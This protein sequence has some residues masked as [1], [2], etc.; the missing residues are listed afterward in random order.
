MK[1]KLEILSKLI[2]EIDLLPTADKVSTINDI[3]EQ[4]HSISPFA[5]EPVDFVKWVEADIVEANDYNPN[6]VAPP[7][8]ELLRISI[9]SDGYTQ[10]VV[11]NQEDDKLVVVD[12]FHRT[13]V[14]KECD[15]VRIR[16]KG[17]LPVVQIRA[18][19]VDKSDRIASTIRHNRARG[20]HVVESMSDIVVELKN[21]N[22]TNQRICRELGMDEDEVLRLCQITGLVGLF[23]DQE[24][25]KAWDVEGHITEDDFEELTDDAANYSESFFARTV[26]TK[27]PDRVFHTFDKWECHKAGFYSSSPPDGLTKDD[28]K[29]EYRRFLSDIPRFRKGLE[30][31]VSEWPHSCE[32]YLTNASMNRIAWLGQAALCYSAGIS[33]EFRGGFGLLTKDEQQA[34]NELALECLNKWIVNK[35]LNAI[36]LLEAIP[37]RQSDIY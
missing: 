18:E 4:L 8:M 32:H 9:V 16:T 26:N 35:G 20:K 37:D 24:F 33:S 5:S 14:G 28:C 17:Y 12:G 23:E 3:R 19:Q 6:V 34:A 1:P 31:V 10:P 2:A 25:S 22:W 11:A 30:G 36:T 7:E 27:D 15:D 13:R 21:R 29:E